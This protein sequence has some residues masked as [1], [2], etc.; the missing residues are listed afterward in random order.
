MIDTFEELFK[1]V[2]KL[3]P[4]AEI[5]ID[6]DEKIIHLKDYNENQ[7]NYWTG[8]KY[9]SGG[10]SLG[11]WIKEIGNYLFYASDSDP[12]KIYNVIKS[13]SECEE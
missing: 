12:Q 2:K 13:I 7:I 3:Y 4:N 9:H 11:L 8:D 6:E 1:K 10:Y 5:E